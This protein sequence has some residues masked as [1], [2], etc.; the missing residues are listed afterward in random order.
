[1]TKHGYKSIPWWYI[2]MSHW[3]IWR[4]PCEVRACW[5]WTEERRRGSGKDIINT[6]DVWFG[7]CESQKPKTYWVYS[8]IN[9]FLWWFVHPKINTSLTWFC[10]A[11]WVFPSEVLNPQSYTTY[12]KRWRNDPSKGYDHTV[13][14]SC[15]SDMSCFLSCRLKSQP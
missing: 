5:S 8:K 1:M 11:D 3:T 4:K 10:T 14:I 6:L 9:K 12:R 2:F 13:Q 7:N 15:K